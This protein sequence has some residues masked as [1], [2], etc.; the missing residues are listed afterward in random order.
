M[1]RLTLIF[2]S[3]SAA[4]TAVAP[5]HASIPPS[6]P[7]VVRVAVPVPCLSDVPQPPNLYHDNLKPTSPLNVL[8]ATALHDRLALVDFSKRAIADL[9]LCATIPALK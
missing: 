5:L 3:L 9:T 8:Y 1:K 6:A 7:N 2:A 4:C